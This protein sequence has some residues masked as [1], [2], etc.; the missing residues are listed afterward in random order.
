MTAPSCV[1]VTHATSI[2]YLRFTSPAL[3]TYRF[4]SCAL[5]GARLVC[6][7]ESPTCDREC[8]R[9]C[10]ICEDPGMPHSVT[11]QEYR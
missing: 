2:F 4:Q 11:R 8:H 3:A 10:A 5:I 9:C 1:G 6:L 7:G